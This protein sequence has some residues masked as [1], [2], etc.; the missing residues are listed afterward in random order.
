VGDSDASASRSKS[1]TRPS[2][3]QAQTRLGESK[4]AT[5]EMKY[6]VGQNKSPESQMPG[7]VEGTEEDVLLSEASNMDSGIQSNEE[8]PKYGGQKVVPEVF[9]ESIESVGGI[10]YQ[11]QGSSTMRR[12]GSPYSMGSTMSSESR[13]VI[14]FDSGSTFYYVKP[15]VDNYVDSSI[16]SSKNNNE[17]FCL[18]EDCFQKKVSPGYV[19]RIIYSRRRNDPRVKRFMQTASSEMTEMLKFAK[20]DEPSTCVSS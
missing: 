15:F 8:Y 10:G 2:Y 19:L 14:F 18:V 1:Q 17:L 13:N 5:D 7:F 4:T 12:A 11:D 9:D 3:H 20:H 16:H 6:S